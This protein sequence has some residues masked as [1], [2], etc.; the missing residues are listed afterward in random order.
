MPYRVT[1][2]RKAQKALRR[3]SPDLR[4]RAGAEID[5]LREN[6]RPAGSKPLKGKPAGR[7]SLRF[8]D[9]WRI[10][11]TIEDAVLLVVVI[12]VAN[13]GKVYRKR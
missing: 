5:R 8:A 4:A 1:V 13:R 11:Y 10:I 12:D 2:D 7:W 9:D 3:L 6:P